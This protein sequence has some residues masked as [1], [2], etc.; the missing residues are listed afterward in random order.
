MLRSQFE[1]VEREEILPTFGT[2]AYKPDFGIPD[3]RVLVE[4]KFIGQKT[5][6]ANIQEEILADIPGYLNDST[7]YDGVI[8]VVY[9]HAQQLRDAKP[10]IEDL[11]NVEGIVEV[12]VVP[13][14]ATA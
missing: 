2:K 1:R 8:E 7:K 10:F 11:R 5:K 6:V 13:G 12:I 14:I 3:L 9:D 4:V